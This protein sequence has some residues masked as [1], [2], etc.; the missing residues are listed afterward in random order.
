MRLLRNRSVGNLSTSKKSG[1]RRCVSLSGTPV[2]RLAASMV[3]STTDR[4]M[5]PSSM[6]IAPLYF[7]KRPRTFETTMCRTEK[8]TPE[9]TASMFQLFVVMGSA[10]RCVRAFRAPPGRPSRSVLRGY[11]VRTVPPLELDALIWNHCSVS[12]IIGHGPQRNPRVRTRRTG[13][14][15]HDGGGAARDA[16]VD[17]QS[18]GVGAG[19][20]A[21]IAPLTAHD[22][23]AEPHGR[24][25]NLLRLLCANR[26]RGRRRGARGEYPARHSSGTVAGDRSHERCLPRPDRQRLSQTLPGSSA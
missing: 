7:A 12:G 9:C 6:V 4:V 18:E 14:Q 3:T 1:D 19:R 8:F 10:L 25:P 17:R 21:E 13:R 11:R 16:E 5:S 20:A 15:L 2:S 26:G 24:R 22:P 23:Q